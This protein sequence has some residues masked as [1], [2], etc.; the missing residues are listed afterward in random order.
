[1]WERQFCARKHEANQRLSS[2]TSSASILKVLKRSLSTM[3]Y[4]APSTSSFQCTERFSQGA[5]SSESQRQRYVSL[6]CFACQRL[7]KHG[8][9]VTVHIRHRSTSLTTI[10]FSTSFISIGH[11]FF[12]VKTR[13]SMSVTGGERIGLASGGGIDL[14]MFAKDGATSS[15]GHHPTSTSALFVHMARL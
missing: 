9:R 5:V 7:N 8:A 15:L 6:S 10:H 4:L 11:F 13:V 3:S 2:T 12:W 14:P 1:M